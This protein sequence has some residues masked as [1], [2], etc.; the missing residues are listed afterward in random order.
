MATPDIRRLGEQAAEAVEN[1]SRSAADSRAR[2]DRLEEEFAKFRSA[3]DQMVRERDA[4]IEAL[5]ERLSRAS[6]ALRETQEDLQEARMVADQ[7]VQAFKDAQHEKAKVEV[8]LVEAIKKT[9]ELQA[10]ALANS[11]AAK[12]EIERLRKDVRRLE[13]ELQEA[14]SDSRTLWVPPDAKDDEIAVLRQHIQEQQAQA[15]FEIERAKA[16]QQTAEESRGL[17]SRQVYEL[18]KQVVERDE[19]IKELEKPRPVDTS[20]QDAEIERLHHEVA[21]KTWELHESQNALR[22]TEDHKTDQAQEIT[23]LRREVETLRSGLSDQKAKLT[24]A[25]ELRSASA[26]HV[27]RLERYVTELETQLE[28]ERE[29]RRRD[30]TLHNLGRG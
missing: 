29:R 8:Q 13:L 4:T 15:V 20:R 5:T 6:Q 23:D 28:D 25:H 7:H 11:S 2:A 1:A 17:L 22:E 27:A 9:E 12:Q 21:A 3:S 30:D 24:A 19:R 26:E 16:M 10:T 18:E 14:A